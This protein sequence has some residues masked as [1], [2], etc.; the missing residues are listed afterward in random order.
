MEVTPAG[1]TQRYYIRRRGKTGKHGKV[2][3]FSSEYVF[4]IRKWE[5][6]IQGG[7]RGIDHPTRRKTQGAG[8]VKGWEDKRGRW[9]IPDTFT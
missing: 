7:T 9:H 1:S 8:F 3:G 2:E 6:V 5:A 4:P